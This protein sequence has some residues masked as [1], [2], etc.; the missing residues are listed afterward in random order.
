MKIKN[1]I[2]FVVFLSLFFSC[3]LS[4]A[5]STPKLIVFHSPS[6]HRCIE[7]KKDIMP[8][9]EKEF[10]GRVA[11]E[12]RD[13]GDIENYK[14]MLALKEKYNPDI[15]L[16]LPVFFI[17]GRLLNGKADVRNGLRALIDYSL[18]SSGKAPQAHEMDLVSY[19]NTFTPLAIISAG[20]I[21]G[22][23]PCAFTVIIF[24]IS[25][26][27]LQGY[28]K[29]ELVSIGLSFIFSV[30]LTYL[31]LGI[32]IFNFLYRIGGFWRIITIVNVSIGVFSIILGILAAYDFIKFK[33]TGETEGLLLQLPQ[34]I[35]NKIH[36]IVGLHYRKTKT[37][38]LQEPEA[39]KHLFMLCVTALSTGLLV[40]L[41]EAVCTGQTYLPTIAFILKTTPLKLQ[42]LTYLLLY[43]LMF[44]APLFIIFLF[45]LLGVTSEQFSIV[46]KKR[47]LVIKALMAIL[48]FGLG[49]F[50]LWRA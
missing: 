7:V 11:I 45:A 29:R 13:I 5:F 3:G 12:Y 30:F 50:L 2:F 14:L 8:E 20:L 1:A 43:N 21:D 44:A 4:Y 25:F 40:S 36:Y 24:F 32:G 22:I 47:L 10:K 38:K 6:C 15:E 23:N 27:A 17:E 37:A 28:R 49:V 31:L 16:S 9:I 42:A 34:S 46:L 35:K 18:S 26:L 19:F 48:F 33:K 41:L 39:K